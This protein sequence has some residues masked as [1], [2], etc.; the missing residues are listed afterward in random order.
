MANTILIGAQW[1]DEGKGKIIDVLTESADLV[2]RYQ[3]GN[4]AGHTVELPSGKYIL[5][6]VPSGILR[7]GCRCV[8]GNG[9]VVDPLALVEELNGLSEADVDF[10]G[11]LLISDRAHM[12]LPFHKQ[13]DELREDL[14]GDGKIGT[15]K[16]G[17]GPAYGDKAARV[18]LRM[19]DLL[20][21]SLFRSRLA[22]RLVE[23]NDI[24][25]AHGW[26]EIDSGK[27]AEEMLEA[28]QMLA[29]MITDTV[30]V[31]Q[32]AL[33]KQSGILL[34]GAQ[35]TLLDID[36]GTYPFVT[37]SNTTSAGACAG[38]GIPPHKIDD[39]IGVMKAYTTR[40][41]EGPFPTEDAEL[42]EHFHGMGREFGAT[43]GRPR[44]CGWLDSVGLKF[45][46]QINGLDRLALTNLDGLDGVKTIKIA[47]HYEIDG[48]KIEHFP[49][50]IDVLQKCVPV[51][52]EV[53]GWDE[54]TSQCRSWE[55]LPENA[56]AYLNRIEKI[57]GAKVA[58]VS[59][60]ARRDQTMIR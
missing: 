16:R 45:A 50:D 34:E 46:S 21:P 40:V 1:G 18:G 19:G 43:T 3:G 49:A 23:I 33:R 26:P 60:G 14:K 20:N 36:M 6:L 28:G 12:V 41:G 48:K 2:V 10:S 52:E 15:T 37:S 5:H 35:G 30:A 57:T 58:V 42:S 47:T 22:A 53:P 17:I 38:A 32:E 11:R 4:N 9:V 51:Y 29:P 27:L 31:L 55:E 56:R 24:F 54:D 8:I 7:P 39:V 59:V 44:R 25:R 13:L